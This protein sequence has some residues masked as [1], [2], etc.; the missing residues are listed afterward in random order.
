[1]ERETPRK[2][3]ECT[4]WWVERAGQRKGRKRNRTAWALQNQKGKN[5]KDA[6]CNSV[7]EWIEMLTIYEG[8]GICPQEGID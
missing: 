1:M 5:F 3:N 6:A 8:Y 2:R 4:V 7:T